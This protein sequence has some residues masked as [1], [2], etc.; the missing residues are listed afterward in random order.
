M[1]NYQPSNPHQ[2]T[3]TNITQHIKLH[4]KQNASTRRKT[5]DPRHI[6]TQ[7][8]IPTTNPQTKPTIHMPTSKRTLAVTSTTSHKRP[9][10]PAAQNNNS[11]HQ[12]H[13]LKEYPP[14]QTIHNQI[15]THNQQHHLNRIATQSS[16]PYA[17]IHTSTKQHSN[18]ILT[19]NLKYYKH[20]GSKHNQRIRNHCS[21]HA[22]LIVSKHTNYRRTQRHR[23]CNTQ[24]PSN[25]LS[26]TYHLKPSVLTHH[27]SQQ[28]VHIS[29]PQTHNMTEHAH[30][31]P[32][33]AIKQTKQTFQANKSNSIKCNITSQ[34]SANTTSYALN[35]HH[36]LEVNPKQSSSGNNLNIILNLRSHTHWQTPKAS[37]Q[38]PYNKPNIILSTTSKIHSNTIKGSVSNLRIHSLHARIA[39]PTNLL[40]TSK[41]YLISTIHINSK[42]AFLQINKITT[43]N[44][45]YQVN[46]LTANS[47]IIETITSIQS[48]NMLTNIH[49]GHVQSKIQK[50]NVHIITTNYK[51]RNSGKQTYKAQTTIYTIYTQHQL[52][53]KNASNQPQLKSQL[54]KTKTLNISLNCN[55][56]PSQKPPTTHQQAHNKN[57]NTHTKLG[58]L[59]PAPTAEHLLFNNNY[60]IIPKKANHTLIK[61]S[62]LTKQLHYPTAHM[63]KNYHNPQARANAYNAL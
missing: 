6:K 13:N 18:K 29:T 11:T 34:L 56:I 30:V 32:L 20:T 16:Q 41:Q 21:Y 25:K 1:Q 60:S 35:K 63:L 7:Y 40:K 42:S 50:T 3:I 31:V 45:S 58:N 4:N 48:Y 14:Y 37:T 39:G 59:H 33:R 22:N 53:Y 62:N 51:L 15:Y 26:N 17:E 28:S 44:H 52:E 27:H 46:Q 2:T 10:N 12:I 49:K 47:Q 54:K 38:N 61:E 23:K 55:S 24:K 5:N 8:I 9:R 19:Y 43:L 57:I 36:N